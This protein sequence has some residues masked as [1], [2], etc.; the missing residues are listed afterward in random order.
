MWLEKATGA[1]GDPHE[2]L[3]PRE[4]QGIRRNG[5]ETKH[6]RFRK[7]ELGKEERSTPTLKGKAGRIISNFTP[8][9][10]TQMMA[11]N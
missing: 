9:S 8:M 7:A 10:P 5:K 3:K 4:G 1:S 2:P 6:G 11:H